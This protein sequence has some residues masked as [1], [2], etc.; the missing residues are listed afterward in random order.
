M[1]VEYRFDSL[2][3]AVH[4]WSRPGS[5]RKKIVGGSDPMDFDGLEGM[6]RMVAARSPIPRARAIPA[7]PDV[8]VIIRLS[9]P[10]RTWRN[11]QTHQT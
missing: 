2:P 9:H 1:T 6:R 5:M 4:W 3:I 7:R 8:N 11:W 10:A